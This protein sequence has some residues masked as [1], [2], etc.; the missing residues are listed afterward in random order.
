MGTASSVL[1]SLDLTPKDSGKTMNAASEA[2]ATSQPLFQARVSLLMF[3][4]CE[5]VQEGAQWPSLQRMFSEV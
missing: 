5:D 2:P 3:F 1:V 4:L